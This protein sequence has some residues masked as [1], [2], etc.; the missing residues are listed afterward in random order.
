MACRRRATP[1]LRDTASAAA[2]V[3][4]V[5]AETMVPILSYGLNEAG[6]VIHS[7]KESKGAL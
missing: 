2:Q 1:L 6:R 3:A 4:Q 7:M 5:T